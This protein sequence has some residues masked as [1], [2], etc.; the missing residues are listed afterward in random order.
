MTNKLHP[1]TKAIRIAL[2]YAANP[3]DDL[4]MQA[5]MK[6]EIPFRGVKTPVRRQIFKRLFKEYPINSLEEYERVIRELW[7]AS[8][9]EERYAAIAIALCFKEYIIL[10]SLPLYRM[11]IETGAWWDFVD[12]IAAHLIGTLLRKY[13]EVMKHM[14]RKWIKDEH[15][16]IRRS[17]ILAQIRFKEETDSEMLFTFCEACLDEKVFWIRKAIGWALRDYSKTN[18]DAVREFVKKYID[19][20]SGVTK[21]EAVKYI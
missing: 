8:Y 9:R 21:R 3:D 17:A 15:I 18:P 2:S 7:D 5:Y 20:M 13:P 4:P 14:L 6:S 1:L 11:M 12:E 10:E 16:W 19:R